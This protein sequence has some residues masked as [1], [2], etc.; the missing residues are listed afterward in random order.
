MNIRKAILKKLFRHRYI[1]GRHTE[2]RNVMKGFPPQLLKEVKEEIK[3]LIRE[4]YLFSKISTGKVH[5]SLN[6]RKINEIRD[7]IKDDT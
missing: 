2:I 5:V 4:G 3:N 6:S 1:G 7:E